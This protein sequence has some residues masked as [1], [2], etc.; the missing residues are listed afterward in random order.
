MG[1]GGEPWRGKGVCGYPLGGEEEG[2]GG[3]ALNCDAPLPD[4]IGNTCAFACSTEGEGTP[5]RRPFLLLFLFPP[6]PHGAA[7]NEEMQPNGPEKASKGKEGGIM[8]ASAA[9]WE[10]DDDIWSNALWGLAFM[11]ERMCGYIF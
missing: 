2:K 9:Q 8:C 5:A 4:L 6:A 3:N 1:G 7:K 11:V 10:T